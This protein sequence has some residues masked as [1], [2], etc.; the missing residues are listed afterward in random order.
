MSVSTECQAGLLSIR[1]DLDHALHSLSYRR[2]RCLAEALL[3]CS[4]IL[5]TGSNP[6]SDSESRCC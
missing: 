3:I 2:P 1:S 5:A 4:A 6:S